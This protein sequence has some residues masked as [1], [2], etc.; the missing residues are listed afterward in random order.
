[1]VGKLIKR[2]FRISA[3][4]FIPVLGGTFVFFLLFAFSTRSFANNDYIGA[5]T[6]IFASITGFAAVLLIFAVSILSLLASI[7][8]M[9]TNMYGDY[10]YELF[11]LPVQGWEIIVSKFVTLF[12]W[13]ILTLLTSVLGLLVFSLIVFGSL[14]MLQIDL[15]PVFE[16][17]RNF[18]TDGQMML[19][20][21]N[22][23]ITSLVSGMVIF[24]VGAITNSSRVSGNRAIKTLGLYF[25]FTWGINIIESLLGISLFTNFDTFD[26]ETGRLILIMFYNVLKLALLTYG[27]LWLWDTKLEIN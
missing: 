21:I 8:I 12:I 24:F 4:K 17:I 10:G 6:Q 26:F 13:S 27:T 7:N 25:I 20:A 9:Y 15:R 19:F 14:E 1:M 23:F 16:L 11:T 5:G 3:N 18:V 2:E 22:G